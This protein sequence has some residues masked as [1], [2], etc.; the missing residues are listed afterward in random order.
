MS[1]SSQ[2]AG[3]TELHSSVGLRRIIILFKQ[4]MVVFC[5]LGG[6]LH[7]KWSSCNESH[8]SSCAPT[9][10]YQKSFLDLTIHA[11]MPYFKNET[12]VHIFFIFFT[13]YVYCLWNLSSSTLFPHCSSV[14]RAELLTPEN[15][16]QPFN[17]DVG[18]I[19]ENV[20]STF[21][22]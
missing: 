14:R 17:C 10:W 18:C 7:R 6:Y 5:K 20:K 16:D 13:F 12:V 15:S 22:L 8:R 1:S 3:G 9:K 11:C 4:A 19:Y 21:S 2:I